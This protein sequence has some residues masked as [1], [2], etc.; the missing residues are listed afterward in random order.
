V[1]VYHVHVIFMGFLGITKRGNFNLARIE[2]YFRT[3]QPISA[4][5]RNISIK[6][7]TNIA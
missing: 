1:S 3:S 6:L 5:T 7:T 2:V 4:T